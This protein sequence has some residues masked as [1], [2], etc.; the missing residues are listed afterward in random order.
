[1]KIR[2]RKLEA[3]TPSVAMADIAFNL[4]LFFIILAKDQTDNNAKWEPATAPRLEA[5]VHSR[6]TIVVDEDGKVWLNGKER[7]VQELT[8]AIQKEIGEEPPGK[9]GV[10]L[11]IHKETLAAKFES[12]LE[13]V[14]QAGGEIMHVLQDE[15]K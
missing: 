2:R 6:V 12:I 7:G 5:L 15:K 4:V 14:S 11:K 9:R 13:A 8:V 3:G 10:L 1:M